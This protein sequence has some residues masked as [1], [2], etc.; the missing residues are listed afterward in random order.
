M[1]LLCAVLALAWARLGDSG[2]RPPPTLWQPESWRARA[3]ETICPF[4][5]PNCDDDGF[6]PELI[7]VLLLFVAVFCCG[8]RHI[9][10]EPALDKEMDKI[11]GSAQEIPAAFPD[12]G[13]WIGAYST[14]D[15]TWVSCQMTIAFYPDGK[16]AGQIRDQDGVFAMQGNF[17]F[18]SGKVTWV[19]TNRSVKVHVFATICMDPGSALE[20]NGRYT[21][22][23]GHC[24]KVKVSAPWTTDA[25]VLPPGGELGVP[26]AP[27]LRSVSGSRAAVLAK[28]AGAK[29]SGNGAKWVMKGADASVGE[30]VVVE[31]VAVVPV[32]VGQVAKTPKLVQS[33]TV[34]ELSEGLPEEW[35][36]MQ[37][38]G[39][40]QVF[41]VHRETG[42][43]TWVRPGA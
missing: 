10:K 13:D 12:R 1:K 23:T 35:Q 31:K 16:L 26:G 8:V 24:G 7:V 36:C 15:S 20:I 17:D 37:A 32:D 11:K 40:G 41:Y 19:E 9:C 5:D 33:R 25:Q 38:P 42:T 22:T 39:N 21:S 28:V 6:P 27:A 18:K 3:L 43:A 4:E 30:V 14:T 29:I 34:A 2:V